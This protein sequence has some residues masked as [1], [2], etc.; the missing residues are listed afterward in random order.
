MQYPCFKGYRINVCIDSSPPP[1]AE[2]DTRSI[3]RG[4]HVCEFSFPSPSSGCPTKGKELNF[5]CHLATEVE[6]TD[7]FI[8]FPVALTRKE[9]Q[10]DMCKIPFPVT[11]TVTFIKI[12]LISFKII[13]DIIYTDP[14]CP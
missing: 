2:F 14:F 12:V 4:V 13:F 3:L 8:S 9:T 10:T 5:P 6:R 1:Q 11:I 7:R